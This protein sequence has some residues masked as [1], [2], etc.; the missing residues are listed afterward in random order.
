MVYTL[1]QQQ[2]KVLGKCMGLGNKVIEIGVV[3]LIITS[4]EPLDEFI[5]PI[6]KVWTL[7]GIL[8]LREGSLPPG[9]TIRVSL[10]LV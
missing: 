4:C 10:H 7:Q 6:P 5:V 8:I 9:D 2:F 1:D 3:F